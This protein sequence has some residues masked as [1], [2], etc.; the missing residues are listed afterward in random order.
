M[1]GSWEDIKAQGEASKEDARPPSQ[2]GTE[3]AEFCQSIKWSWW[4][5]KARKVDWNLVHVR[6][7]ATYGV[8][9]EG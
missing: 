2:P 8:D 4:E 1:Q 7:D 3:R 6:L 9:R 5:E